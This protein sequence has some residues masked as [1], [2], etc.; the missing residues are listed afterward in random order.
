[1]KQW[2]YDK[3]REQTQQQLVLEMKLIELGLPPVATPAGDRRP[4]STF[5]IDTV[6]NLITKFN[7]HDVKSFLLSFEKIAQL[8]QFP[9][10]TYTAILQAHL[11]WKALKVF[12]ELSV[13][14]CQDYPKLK[15]ALLTAYA[16]VP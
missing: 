14:D 15:E 4:T 1:M 7:E 5:R 13:K 11:T 12:T 6:V 8:N 16:I 9:Q 10:D 2:E 3:R